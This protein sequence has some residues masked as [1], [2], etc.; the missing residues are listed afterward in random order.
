[1]REHAQY[2]NIRINEYPRRRKE[3]NSTTLSVYS[4]LSLALMNSLEMCN[5]HC[6]ISLASKENDIARETTQNINIFSMF[7][8]V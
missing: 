1:M 3:K 5:L 6:V 7:V 2:K 8:G 4:T